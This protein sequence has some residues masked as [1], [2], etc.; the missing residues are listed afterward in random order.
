MAR[1][2]RTNNNT[3]NTNSSTEK[4]TFKKWLFRLSMLF[5]VGVLLIGILF[6]AIYFGAFGELP[7]QTDLWNKKVPLASEVYASN[8]TLLGKYYVENRSSIKYDD[9]SEHVINALVA[10]EDHRYFKHK[11]FDAISYI[12]VMIKSILLQ[13]K[14]YYS[15][16]TMPV[17][18]I[19]EA[20]VA[21]RLEKIYNKED[22][23]TLYLNTVPFGELAFGIGTVKS[24]YLLQSTF[25]S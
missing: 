25:T 24:N 6:L 1:A 16:L 19:K 10:T 11:G 14:T 20:I 8:G 2:S 5:M 22:I 4:S 18:K 12:R 3:H 13:S 21:V 17:N 23:I 15:F 9:I 7:T